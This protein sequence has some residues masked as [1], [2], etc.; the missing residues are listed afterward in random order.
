MS[1]YN[2]HI[3]SETLYLTLSSANTFWQCFICMYELGFQ[4]IKSDYDSAEGHQ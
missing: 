1:F 3:R 4:V 2:S